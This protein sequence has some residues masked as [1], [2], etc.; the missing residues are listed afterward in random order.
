[1]GHVGRLFL[2]LALLSLVGLASARADWPGRP[3]GDPPRLHQKG[4]PTAWIE[5]PTRSTWL[6]YGS[7]CWT[8]LC[9]DMVPPAMRKDIPRVAVKRGDA[10]RVHLSFAPSTAAVVLLRGDRPRTLRLQAKRVLVWR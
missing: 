1:M 3:K 10:V 5:T 6:A 2:P 8:T 9:V 4:P 7:Y